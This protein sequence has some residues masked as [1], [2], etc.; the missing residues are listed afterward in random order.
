MLG[1]GHFDDAARTWD[2]GWEDAEWRA[3]PRLRLDLRM[4]VRS[5]A[6]RRSSPPTD[7]EG[8]D[9]PTRF[10]NYYLGETFDA[11]RGLAWMERGSA[12]T[13]TPG[14][15]RVASTARRDRCTPRRTSRFAEISS[16]EPGTRHEPKPGIVVYD[17]G[18]N[19]TGWAELSSRSAARDRD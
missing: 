8:A 1:S 18:Q 14:R 9:G 5:T 11:R 7:V 19:L 6:P 12:S 10:D 15:P 17:I 16:R 2:W 13:T 4:L 3:T